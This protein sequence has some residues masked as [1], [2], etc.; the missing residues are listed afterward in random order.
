VAKN[1]PAPPKLTARDRRFLAY[2]ERLRV[3]R[4]YV[5][6]FEGDHWER[7]YLT[8]EPSPD[9][10]AQRRRNVN[11]VSAK[12]GALKPFLRGTKKAVAPK[13]AE[14]FEALRQ[15]A[16]VPNIKGLKAVPIDAG[17]PRKLRVYFSNQR[18]TVPPKGK[19]KRASIKTV[20]KVT[21]KEGHFQ[22]EFYAFPRSIRSLIQ[23]GGFENLADNITVMLHGMMRNLPEG[24]YLF[25]HKSY[26]LLDPRGE[27]RIFAKRASIFFTTDSGEKEF[28]V[29]GLIG[30]VRLSGGDEQHRELIRQM[31]EARTVSGRDRARERLRARERATR[32]FVQRRKSQGK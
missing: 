4:K 20:R 9:D 5:A 32:A 30:V 15:Y 16:Q 14:D 8:R 10:E 24:T 22:Q 13:R 6:G 27:R 1:K 23:T 29:S 11:R 7:M 2:T 12:F 19:E 3:L 21:V 31:K 18:V 17:D 28:V 25:K 26:L